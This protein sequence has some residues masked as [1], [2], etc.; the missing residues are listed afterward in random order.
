MRP[1]T[2]ADRHTMA[3]RAVC[4]QRRV[5]EELGV[6]PPLPEQEGPANGLAQDH[7]GECAA[8]VVGG[9]QSGVAVDVGDEGVG[10]AV[11]CRAIWA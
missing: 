9:E 4:W 10:A 1:A 8:A 7:V 6:V 3:V 2:H 11:S 5:L